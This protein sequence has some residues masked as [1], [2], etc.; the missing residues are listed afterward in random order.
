MAGPD[1]NFAFAYHELFVQGLGD[2]RRSDFEPELK[3][4]WTNDP[5]VFVMIKGVTHANPRYPVD[6]FADAR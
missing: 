3:L 6:S 5:V 2:G 4:V 1:V